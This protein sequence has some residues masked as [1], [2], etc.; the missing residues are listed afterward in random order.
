MA[1][2]NALEALGTPELYLNYLPVDETHG[3]QVE[4]PTVKRRKLV[5]MESMVSG[6]MD[7]SVY[8]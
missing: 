4:L 7:G 5:K 1:D 2:V 3:Y 8:D 6:P